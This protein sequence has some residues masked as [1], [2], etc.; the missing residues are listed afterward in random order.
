MRSILHVLLAGVT[1]AALLGV[2]QAESPA[3]TTGVWIQPGPPAVGVGNRSSNSAIGDNSVSS[4]HVIVQ[5]PP[6][7]VLGYLFP[8]TVQTPSTQPSDNPTGLGGAVTNSPGITRGGTGS[9]SSPSAGGPSTTSLPGVDNNPTAVSNSGGITR[10]GSTVMND[11]TV[12]RQG[13]WQ[14]GSGYSSADT[15]GSATVSS[16][17][18]LSSAGSGYGQ[19][20]TAGARSANS[21]PVVDGGG[22]A[23]YNS[24]PSSS[25]VVSNSAGY[26]RSA[27]PLSARGGSPL[28]SG[29]GTSGLTGGSS[30]P[31]TGSGGA[32]LGRGR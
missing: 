11:G 8:L 24:D 5:L 9:G 30:S 7:S 25:N 28:S 20:S 4:T 19:D 12:I 27:P 1:A 3:S 6:E 29:S 31:L 15:A 22:S 23:N 32:N 26:T 13:S 14:G 2:V 10:S 16:S 18:G 17:T 21:A